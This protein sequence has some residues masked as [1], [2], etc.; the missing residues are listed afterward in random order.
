MKELFESV[1]GMMKTFGLMCM[2]TDVVAQREWDCWCPTC[3]TATQDPKFAQGNVKQWSLKCCER[4]AREQWSECDVSR[5]DTRGVRERRLAAQEEG[6]Q[7]ASQLKAGDIVSVQARND[8]DQ[9]YFVGRCV[10]GGVTDDS[11]IVQKVPP[12]KR[13]V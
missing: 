4:R 8:P 1:H 12:G 9:L 3:L 2:R 5:K 6:R 11:P 7:L 10:E 13:T